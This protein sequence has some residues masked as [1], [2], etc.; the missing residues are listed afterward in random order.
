MALLQMPVKVKTHTYGQRSFSYAAPHLWN[1]LPEE[2]KNLNT[3]QQK[4]IFLLRKKF[5]KSRKL[6][7]NQENISCAKKTF[8]ASRNI[9]LVQEFFFLQ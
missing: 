7:L 6:F 9:F 4:M 5:L 1:S 3:T 2:I 8:L